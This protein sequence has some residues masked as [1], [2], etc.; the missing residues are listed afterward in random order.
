MDFDL[1]FSIF[2]YV[3]VF[4]LLTMI[5]RM[6][7]RHWCNSRGA[8]RP[9]IKSSPIAGMG[10]FATKLYQAGDVID[11]CPTVSV[12]ED[13]VIGVNKLED[14]VFQSANEGSNR[15]LVPLSTCGMYNHS[16]SPNATFVVNSND[17]ID[18]LATSQIAPGTEITVNYGPNYWTSR[19]RDPL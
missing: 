3:L 15:V 4:L 17:S 5:A 18:I 7:C 13:T 16:D 9:E 19:N 2:T 14:Y 12:P 10:V 11:Q 6:Y 8:C 1:L